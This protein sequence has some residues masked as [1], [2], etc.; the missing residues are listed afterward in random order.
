[1][2]KQTKSS[3][4]SL[5]IERTFN[6][7]PQRLWAYWTDP[8]KYARW[9]NPAPGR[10][11]VI[12]EYDVRAGG[13]VRFDMPGPDGSKNPQEGVFHTVRPYEELVTGAPDKS[14]L[15]M[16]RFAPVGDR[17]RMTVEVVGV[18]Q[19]YW[20]G[21][22]RG[23]NAGLDKLGARLVEDAGDGTNE[24]A[25]S[26]VFKAPRARVFDAF[27]DE[28]KLARWWGPHGF[29]ITTEEFDARPGGRW[30]FTMHGP[31]GQ[32][33]PNLM[34]YDEVDVPTRIVA[35]HGGG[36]PGR[37]GTGFRH[38]IDFEDDSDGTRVTMRLVFPSAEARAENVAVY[39]SVEGARET[40]ARLEALLGSGVGLL[41]PG[42]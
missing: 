20:E 31:N 36:I 1:M 15:I 6:A 13:R 5:R 28:T 26:R 30:R 22:T 10:D 33:Y 4:P 23:W 42:V 9:F 21:A 39:H 35:R 25:I 29:T 19:A 7:S 37:A 12:H 18:P 40:F 32:D 3:E 17:T 16:V 24:V 38:V 34:V 11:L 14:F 2:T 27:V 8:T 41:G